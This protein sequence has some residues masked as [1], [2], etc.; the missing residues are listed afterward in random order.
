MFITTSSEGKASGTQR[1]FDC[2]FIFIIVHKTNATSKI[3]CLL[4]HCHHHQI[5]IMICE[6]FGMETYSNGPNNSKTPV[7]YGDISPSL[8]CT[9]SLSE[10][11]DNKDTRIGKK[12]IWCLCGKC[13]PMQTGMDS[14]CC[15]EMAKI[16]E[17]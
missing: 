17:Q 13:Q 16:S 15:R 9:E 8:S 6:V 14:L 2:Q 10:S 11:N 3:K 12:D 7:C 1:N 5:W 4:P